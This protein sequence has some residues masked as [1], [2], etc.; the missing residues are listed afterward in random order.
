MTPN[1]LLAALAAMAFVVG[2]G[3]LLALVAERRAVGDRRRAGLAAA[4]ARIG[5]RFGVPAPPAGLPSRIAAA[6]LPAGTGI[7]DVMAMK[8][9]AAITGALSGVGLLTVAPGR[10]GA[11]VL[12]VLATGGFMAPDL[13]MR[14]RARNRARRAG[15]ELAD[16]LDLLRV[17]VEAGLPTGR[18][19]HEVGLRRRGLVAAELR[20]VAA[21]LE[22]GLPRAEALGALRGAL[23]LPEIAVL[24]AALER[25]D[26]HGAPLGPALEALALQARAARAER[27]RERS[28]SASPRI[29]LVIALILV[30]ATILMVAAALVHGLIPG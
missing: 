20:A 8:A 13:W 27:L 5:R 19:L 6:G 10:G 7:A 21:R 2:V 9:G 30:P 29:Q 25:S 1:A 18:A 12:V 14:R 11:L 24:V 28:A 15:I 4:L 17:A 3:D 26:R 23:P 22:L 16:V